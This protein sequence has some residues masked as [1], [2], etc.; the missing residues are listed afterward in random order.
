[1]P[2]LHAAATLHATPHLHVTPAD[3]GPHE[4]QGPLDIAYKTHGTRASPRKITDR[5]LSSF[6]CT[7]TD[8]HDIRDLHASDCQ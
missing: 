1:M 4:R 6:F 2:P 5:N 8:V 3:D 7:G